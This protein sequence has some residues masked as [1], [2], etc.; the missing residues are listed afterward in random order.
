MDVLKVAGLY[1]VETVWDREGSVRQ[2][3]QELGESTVS[4]KSEVRAKFLR[5]T[6]KKN[7]VGSNRKSKLRVN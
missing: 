1:D 3:S 7:E 6:F 5:Y 2:N 4:K